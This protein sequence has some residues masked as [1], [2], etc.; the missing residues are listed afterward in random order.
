MFIDTTCI[1]SIYKSLKIMLDYDNEKQIEIMLNDDSEDLTARW[2][3]KMIN[4]DE[5]LIHHL[6]RRLDGAERDITYNL[7]SLLLEDNLF[8]SFLNDYKITFK[9]CSNGDVNMCFKGVTCD[10]ND[11]QF[12]DKTK[13]YRLASR[14][15]FNKQSGYRDTCVNGFCSAINIQN[16]STYGLKLR[17]CPEF[18]HDLKGVFSYFACDTE[19][20]KMIEE[21][22][23]RSKYYC[24]SY[25]IPVNECFF[26]G[27]CYE[28]TNFEEFKKSLM[29]AI[30]VNIK[31]G[32]NCDC[33]SVSDNKNI[34]EKSIYNII[35]FDE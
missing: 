14:L 20:N 7:R 17:N 21:Y 34:S 26:N 29:K 11:T 32:I 27:K 8:S 3:A 13:G 23:K 22:K 33:L 24:I 9:S 35:K 2:I 4:I 15:C 10:F 16:D 5:V 25:L 6:T 30:V 12:L 28:E 1:D 18:L 19:Y 31:H